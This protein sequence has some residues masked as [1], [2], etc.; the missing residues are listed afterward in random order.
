MPKQKSN[1][2]IEHGVLA[3]TEIPSPKK[4]HKL[5]DTEL[6]QPSTPKEVAITKDNSV[7][8]GVK[9]STVDKKSIVKH[10][11]NGYHLTDNQISD[12][13]S[14][15]LRPA[16][17]SV[18]S[19][20]YRL[21]WGFRKDTTSLVGYYTLAKSCNICTKTVKRIIQSLISLGLITRVKLI[22][23]IDQ[24][25]SI[26]K[27][28]FPSTTKST[29]DKMSTV[30]KK[31]IV[32][33]NHWGQ[34]V[35][36]RQIFQTLGTKVPPNNNK[37][38]IIKDTLSHIVYNMYI[39]IGQPRVS[40]SKLEKGERVLEDLLKEGYTMEEIKFSLEELKKIPDVK[41]ITLLKHTI[42]QSV[43]KLEK[44]K[45]EE[46]FIKTQQEKQKQEHIQLTAQELKQKAITERI[47]NLPQEER[48]KLTQ[49]ARELTKN[50]QNLPFYE[51]IVR[52]KE[53][54]IINQEISKT[55]PLDEEITRELGLPL[56]KIP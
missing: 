31:S 27:V 14:S 4:S 40:K 33:Q 34:N 55:T 46:D 48:Q 42:S 9:M 53:R 18:Y 39:Y 15:H 51:T 12:Y 47:N 19:R 41:D 32:S 25:G 30:D 16:Q 38:L 7:A 56:V 26:Y 49:K 21:S 45:K 6:F 10:F 2:F 8:T 5:E 1:P 44:K 22:N 50:Q 35:Y 54:E 17:L 37:V 23:K 13:L 28:I 29:I 3:G 20:L 52:T 11:K 36:S 43:A 24:K